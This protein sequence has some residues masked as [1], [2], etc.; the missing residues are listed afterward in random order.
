MLQA[1]VQATACCGG[2]AREV[3]HGGPLQETREGDRGPVHTTQVN[4]NYPRI[5]YMYEKNNFHDA[6]SLDNVKS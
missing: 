4:Y 5:L 6:A 2:P 3:W 1:V